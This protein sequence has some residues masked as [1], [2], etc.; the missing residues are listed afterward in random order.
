MSAA[1]TGLAQSVQTR[2]VQHAKAI[3]MDT[4]MVLSRFAVERFLY[5]L[6]R[7][8][9]AEQF[10]LKGALMML[11]WLGET[12]RP[13]RDVDLLGFGELSEES[14]ARVFA[15]VCDVQVEPD[16]MRF[17]SDSIRVAAIRAEDA[18][19]GLRATLDGRLGNARLRVQVDVGIGDA[20]T[21]EPE[22]LDYPG[23]LDLPQAR[24][25]AYRP[26]TS[27][28]EKLHAMVVLGAA[29][30]RMRDFFD[31]YALSEQESFEG[32]LL[33]RA[34]RATFERRRTPIPDRL[35][36]A[37]TP[38][39]AAMKDKQLQWQGFIRKNALTS[40]PADLG[41]TIERLATF[42]GP[43]IDAARIDAPLASAW[44]PAGPWEAT[45]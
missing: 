5:R 37:L 24:L 29:N 15:A 45:P 11:V 25:R 41:Q 39:F 23:M 22:W 9:H 32:A 30:S 26:E 35:P 42:L 6:S 40:A 18:Y 28:A 8:P 44:P 16:G 13:T 33:A 4:N 31:I 14:L 7:S 19:G 2:L 27:I 3:R 34:V 20:V 12:I 38:E 1:V 43:V 10:V 17:L 21:P 36:L